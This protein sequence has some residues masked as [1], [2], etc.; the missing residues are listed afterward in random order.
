MTLTITNIN[1]LKFAGKDGYYMASKNTWAFKTE[2]GFYS[3]DG[4]YPYVPAGGKKALQTILDGGGF[5][6]YD[7]VK[8][9][10]PIQEV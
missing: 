3:D 9:I 4:V 5:T 10:A 6:N 2:K 1:G 8:F 7:G